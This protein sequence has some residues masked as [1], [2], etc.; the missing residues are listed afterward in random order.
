MWTVGVVFVAGA[1]LAI[2]R[3]RLLTIATGLMLL[4]L[5]V[6]TAIALCI[7]ERN[8]NRYETQFFTVK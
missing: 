1:M 3:Y 6:G 8:M 5:A 7:T 4:G 2:G